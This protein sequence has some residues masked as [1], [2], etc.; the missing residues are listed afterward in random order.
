[1]FPHV[2][3]RSYPDS[4]KFL[5]NLNE[6]SE[7]SGINHLQQQSP[8]LYKF[9][10]KFQVFRSK[11]ALNLSLVLELNANVDSCSILSLSYSFFEWKNTN[12]FLFK[13]IHQESHK[14][15]YTQIWMGLVLLFDPFSVSDQLLILENLITKWKMFNSTFKQKK[16]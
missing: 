14:R 7:K 5:M 4:S 6:N 8:Y 16:Q 2:H 12:C 13:R 11:K 1:M 10:K 9:V 15:A 3:K